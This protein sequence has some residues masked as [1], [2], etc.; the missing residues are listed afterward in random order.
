MHQSTSSLITSDSQGKF[1][2][3]N[4]FVPT[5]K[6]F[7]NAFRTDLTRRRS[8]LGVAVE[9]SSLGKTLSPRTGPFLVV[10]PR[11]LRHDVSAEVPGCP[12]A[13][14]PQFSQAKINKPEW[15]PTIF[16]QRKVQVR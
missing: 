15:A 2:H 5:A 9:R 12:L 4:V 3:L 16:S 14:K 1:A 10:H 7:Q 6:L 11:V 13:F 8:H